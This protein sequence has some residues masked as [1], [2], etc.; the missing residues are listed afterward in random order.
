[1]KELK[2]MTKEILK[3]LGISSIEKMKDELLELVLSND[4]KIK[5]DK[6]ME[7]VETLETDWILNIYSNM[8]AERENLKQDYTPQSMSQLVAELAF[9]DGKNITTC[10]D[11]CCGSGSLTL[12]IHKM[13][14]SVYFYLE[15]LDE[16][17]IP[18]LLFNLSIRNCNA[19]VINGDI[20]KSERKILYKVKKGDKYSSIERCDIPSDYVI[21]KVDLA[22]S[23]PPFNI[24]Y[25]EPDAKKYLDWGGYIQKGK[26]D[27]LFILKCINQTKEDGRVLI[28][29]SESILYRTNKNDYIA[30][31]YIVDNIWLRAVIINPENM[32]ENTKI[33]T[34]VF[35]VDKTKADSSV[36]F[37]DASDEHT[38]YQRFRKG[39][40][41]MSTYNF[42]KTYNK[43]DED[44]IL[45]IINRI[46]Y[47]QNNEEEGYI[48]VDNDFLIKKDYD[49][50]FR[51]K[52][53]EK[54]I[55]DPW[56]LI[57]NH[58]EQRRKENEEFDKKIKILE[59][60][61][62]HIAP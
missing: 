55:L 11:A 42:A 17:V 21:P 41:N 9:L 36:C 37:V 6:Y 1:M 2:D 53:E 22:I 10:Y 29:E 50:S 56:T 18:F 39:A 26:T 3:A 24:T 46:N 40:K 15:E 60:T 58:M 54:V 14:P 19:E 32:F 62:K 38:T 34:I 27:Y 4:F 52:E 28:I 48:T 16:N 59:E 61:L 23:N 8:L 43:Y 7:V 49:L 31:K 45:N 47:K 44:N 51:K 30:R 5:Y 12:A 20:I 13:K 57:Y 33:K 35:F 25:E